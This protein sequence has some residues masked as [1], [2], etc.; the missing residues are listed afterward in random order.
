MSVERIV[1]RVLGS[2]VYAASAPAKAK[3]PLTSALA[4]EI[5]ALAEE[6]R[7]LLMQHL[8]AMC[9]GTDAASQTSEDSRSH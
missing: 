1:E 5:A 3:V 4:R 8:S 6:D 2:V 9:A 7:Q